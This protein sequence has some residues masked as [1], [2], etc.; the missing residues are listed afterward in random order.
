VR[1]TTCARCSRAPTRTQQAAGVFL[2]VRD[3]IANMMLGAIGV[4]VSPEGLTMF[5]DLMLAQVGFHN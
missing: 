5:A 2:F 4:D 1:D 3:T